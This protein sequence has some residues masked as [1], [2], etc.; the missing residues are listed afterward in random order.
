MAAQTQDA[1]DDNSMQDCQLILGT[2]GSA[3]FRPSAL[4]EIAMQMTPEESEA[5]IK[6]FA[7][8]GLKLLDQVKRAVG[9]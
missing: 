1:P 5:L 2:I 9:T 3:S 7:P 6:C 8:D 4:T